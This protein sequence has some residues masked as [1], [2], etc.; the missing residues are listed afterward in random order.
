MEK[1]N[2]RQHGFEDSSTF[3]GRDLRGRSQVQGGA[4]LK[5]EG[6]KKCFSDLCVFLKSRETITAK[7][8]RIRRLKVGDANTKYF[9]FFL[10]QQGKRN[11]I[12][13]RVR[14]FPRLYATSLWFL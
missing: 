9:H 3:C 7:Q 13:N 2:I 6:R 10:K 11:D 14:W 4:P 5:V 8:S 12:T 1:G